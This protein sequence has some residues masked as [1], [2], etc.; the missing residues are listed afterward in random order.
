MPSSSRGCVAPLR[1]GL[2]RARLPGRLAARVP[3]DLRRLDRG[4]GGGAGDLHRRARARRAAAR[5]ARGSPPAAAAASTPRSSR[6][7]RCPRREPAAARC[8]RA[9]C[10]SPAADRRRSGMRARDRRAPGAERAR[11]RGADDRDGRHA[12]GRGACG[13]ARERRA[14][15]ATSRCSTRSTRS[16]PSPAASSRRSS[17][18]RC[19]A[20]ARRCGSPPRSTCWWRCR[21]EPSIGDGPA[22]RAATGGDRVAHAAMTPSLR[23]RPQPARPSDARADDSS[24]SLASGDRRLRVLPD[25]AGLVSAARAA[26]RRLGLHLRPGAGGRARRHRRRRAAVLARRPRPAGD[27]RR[28]RRRCL[29]E[30]AAVARPSRSA[31]ASPCSRSRCCRSAAPGSPRRSPAGRS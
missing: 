20:R 31:I 26:A 22:N 4:V 12:A 9:R 7:S 25:G 5:P 11:A 2:L 28:V 24:C 29:L 17:C 10:I 6:S 8:W 1:L 21:A 15:A 30:A 3:A 19:S 23:Y 13:H 16:A 14:P 27:A 18:S